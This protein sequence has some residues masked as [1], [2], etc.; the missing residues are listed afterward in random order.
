MYRYRVK[1]L[2]GH[3][4]TIPKEVRER[5]GLEVGDEVEILVMGNKLVLRPIR[6]PEDPVLAMLGLAE[7][8]KVELKEIEKVVIEELEEKLK[9][10]S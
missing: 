5:W 9:R 2:S 6:L 10:S 4:V 7:G 3:R 1:I 8:E